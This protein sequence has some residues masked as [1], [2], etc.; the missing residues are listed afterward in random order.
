[1]TLSQSATVEAESSSF[2]FGIQQ[3]YEDSPWF[4]DSR[5]AFSPLD[6]VESETAIASNIHKATSLT[7]SFAGG[8][9]LN[10]SG[11]VVGMVTHRESSD[12]N[13]HRILSRDQLNDFLIDLREGDGIVFTDITRPELPPNYKFVV[14]DGVSQADV[15]QLARATSNLHEYAV[16]AGIPVSDEP[17]TIYIEHDRNNLTKVF[18]TVEGWQEEDALKYWRGHSIPGGTAS[19]N[20][21]YQL[22]DEPL[23]EGEHQYTPWIVDGHEIVHGMYQFGLG[24][25]YTDRGWFRRHHAQSPPWMGEGLA[26]VYQQLAFCHANSVP[27]LHNPWDKAAALEWS[28]TLENID[29]LEPEEWGSV[30]KYSAGAEAIELLATIVGVSRLFDFYTM[31]RPNEPWQSTFRRAYGISVEEFYERFNQH[32]AAGLP[33]L[34]LPIRVNPSQ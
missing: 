12:G 22:V 26:M 4:Y 33:D 18:V 7:P 21:A 30:Y 24:G 5:F 27:Y 16:F 19:I 15:H 28:G 25:L 13:G 11:E 1:M 29:G 3:V 23:P 20:L 10:R 34:E 9:V 2:A 14:G 6:P 8:P 32:K 31:M 17:K